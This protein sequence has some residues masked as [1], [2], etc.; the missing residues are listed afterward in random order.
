MLGPRNPNPRWLVLVVAVLLAGPTTLIIAGSG[1]SQ[2]CATNGITD[3]PLWI[4]GVT[5]DSPD[6]DDDT[7]ITDEGAIFVQEGDEL[8]FTVTVENRVPDDCSELYDTNMV[9]ELRAKIQYLPTPNDSTVYEGF[10]K[11]RCD[12]VGVNQDCPID[13]KLPA[14]Q[15]GEVVT[16]G[17]YTK[18]EQRVRFL[19]QDRQGSDWVTRAGAERIIVVGVKPDLRLESVGGNDPIRWEEPADPAQRRTLYPPADKQTKFKVTVVNKGNYPLW[20]PNGGTDYGNRTAFDQRGSSDGNLAPDCWDFLR[21]VRCPIEVPPN[22]ATGTDSMIDSGETH[23]RV[24]PECKWTTPNG[25]P[26]GE[27][28]QDG[29]YPCSYRRGQLLDL[30]IKWELREDGESQIRQNA[31][32]NTEVYSTAPSDDNDKHHAMAWQGSGASYTHDDFSFGAFDLQGKAGRFDLKVILDEDAD[33]ES[34]VPETSEGNDNQDTFDLDIFGVD[35]QLAS[36]GIL[37]EGTQKT[38]TDINDPCQAGSRVIVGPTYRNTGTDEAEYNHNSAINRNWRGAVMVKVGQ[39]DFQIAIDNQDEEVLTDNRTVPLTDDGKIDMA[40]GQEASEKQSQWIIPTDPEGGNHTFK[41]TLDESQLYSEG[42]AVLD[43]DRGRVAERT[44]RTGDCPKDEDGN[45]KVIGDEADNTFCLTLYFKDNSAPT[46]EDVKIDDTSQGDSEVPS[47]VEGEA[48]NF[49]A[50]VKDNA[51]ESATAFF[52]HTS[53]DY[54][55]E[56]D[57]TALAEQDRYGVETNLS[58]V[59][60]NEDNLGRWTFQIKASDV[61]NTNWSTPMEFDLVELPKTVTDGTETGDDKL[62]GETNVRGSEAPRYRG[63]ADDP[64]NTFE[65]VVNVTGSGQDGSTEGKFLEIQEPDGTVNKTVQMQ[66]AEACMTDPTL[67]GEEREVTTD[68]DGQPPEDKWAWWKVD[69][70]DPAF[71]DDDIELG[72]VGEFDLVVNVT[73]KFGRI[74]KENFTY[75]LRDRLNHDTNNEEAPFV[76]EDE[77]EFSPT[78]LDPGEK[79]GVRAIAKDILRVERVYLDVTHSDTGDTF[80]QDLRL[81]K[82]G[83]AATNNGTY[84]GS[85]QAGDGGELFARAGTYEVQLVAQD[86]GNNPTTRDLGTLTVNDTDDPSIES[87]TTEPQDTVEAGQEVEFFARISDQTQIQPPT[88]TVTQASAGENVTELV[89]NETTGLWELEDPMVATLAAEGT[90][91]YTLEVADYAGHKVTESGEIEIVANNAPTA[92]NWKPNIGTGQTNYGPAEPTIQTDLVD[93]QGVNRSSIT[94]T[95]NG[96]TVLEEEEG[97]ASIK[98]IPGTCAQCY[99]VSYTPS[100]AYG[101]GEVVTVKVTAADLSDPPKVSGQQTHQFEVDKTGPSATIDLTPSLSKGNQRIIGSTTDVNVSTS[102]T[103]SGPGTARVTVEHLAGTTAA[104]RT[105]LEVED[106]QDSFRL[107][108]L[109]AFQGHGRYRIIVEPTDAVGNEGDS[110]QKIVLFD[111]APPKIQQIPQLNKPRSFIGAN[112]TD[113]SRVRDVSVKFTADDGPQRQIALKLTNGTWSGRIV[114]PDTDQPYPENTTIEFFLQASDFW[115]NTVTTNK[116]T[117]EAGNAVP[118]IEIDKPERGATLQG[119][120]EI[121]WTAQDAETS[122]SD[123][124]ISIWYK[125]GDGKPRE[126]PGAKDIQNTGSYQLDTTL[127]PNGDITLQ[128]I[129]FDGSTFGSDTVDVTVQNLGKAFRSP[130]VRGAEAVDGENVLTPG[131]ET[132]FTVEIDGNVR[133]A[134]ANVTNEDG[135]TVASYDLEQAD[136]GT[137]QASFT[138]PDEPGEYSVDLAALTADGPQK[139]QGAYTFSVQDQEQTESFIPEWTILSVLFAGAVALGAFGL[140]RRWE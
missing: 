7:V 108:E 19:V 121:R 86:F 36:S 39:G 46:I 126:I 101:A 10:G 6:E 114:N 133:A 115:G 62:N 107:P 59:L 80:E 134:W 28:D 11:N 78:A 21:D 120:V 1:S 71:A 26:N 4:T 93:T 38:C 53:A 90:W 106:G 40:S 88:L 31:V 132:L 5:A 18:G 118:T 98:A 55:I 94:M 92:R 13:I 44:D 51:L 123:L 69:S 96:E 116:T 125:Q 27:V 113:V 41:I 70:D 29:E 89:F 16:E 50:T 95:V 32:N 124:K 60:G 33:G 83:E 84:R 68:C 75:E 130:E 136:G 110:V 97:P 105:V 109:D 48:G 47:I 61:N 99:R 91:T 138:A 3:H 25:N 111:D 64:D 79:A 117:F 12:D 58:S 30:P 20:N 66:K 72:W 56:K 87:L 63:T 67:P 137:W 42:T 45:N 15:N 140:A 103:G 74:G 23:E 139:T 131:E 2:V 17:T 54:S 73:D 112:V 22:D 9:D 57:L 34:R 52:N 100:E 127:V 49:T 77:I 81:T 76:P 14:S 37:V 135:E 43:E 82:P 85:F 122:T 104:T 129:V 128:T 65:L 8:E 119:T 24:G 35:L 102:D